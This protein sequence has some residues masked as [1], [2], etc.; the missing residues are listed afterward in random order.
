LHN[1]PGTTFSNAFQKQDY[2]SAK[3][4][5]ISFETLV[6]IIHKWVVDVYHQKENKGIGDVPSRLWDIAVKDMPPVLPAKGNCI[7]ILLGQIAHRAI[8]PAGIELNGLFYNNEQLALLRHVLKPGEKVVVKY[9]PCDLSVVNVYDSIKNYFIPALSTSLE[10]TQ[11]LSLWQHKVIK[12][13]ARLRVKDYVDIVALSVAKEDI[14][15]LVEIEWK[16]ISKS[17]NKQKLARWKGQHNEVIKPLSGEEKNPIILTEQSI[18]SSEKELIGI[19]ELENA[20]Q[21]N[22]DSSN[23]SLSNPSEKLVILKQESTNKS[24]KQSKQKTNNKITHVPS[25]N[26]EQKDD[27]TPDVTNWSADYILKK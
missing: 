5:I 2:D 23:E 25:L 21:T 10:Y 26:I 3:N 14:Q 4:A 27:F 7:D 22:F 15:K 13:Y 6:E 11:G 9:D 1:Q 20:Y 12:E 16:S 18:F 24:K 8:S 19:S 17:A